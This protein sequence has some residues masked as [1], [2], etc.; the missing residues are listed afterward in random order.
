MSSAIPKAFFS[1]TEAGGH[2]PRSPQRLSLPP[3]RPPLSGPLTP[4]DGRVAAPH[5]QRTVSQGQASQVLCDTIVALILLMLLTLLLLG[6]LTPTTPEGRCS[7][8]YKHV[9]IPKRQAPRKLL[10]L[11]QSSQGVSGHQVTT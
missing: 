4:I 11:L 6:P 1:K 9:A 8:P 10:L 5:K 3:A 7:D 2:S